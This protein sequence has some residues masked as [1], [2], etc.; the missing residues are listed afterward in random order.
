VYAVV[1][2]KTAESLKLIPKINKGSFLIRGSLLQI[3][4]Y[5]LKHRNK[6]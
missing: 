3:T 2:I 5:F 1:P 6:T 4:T